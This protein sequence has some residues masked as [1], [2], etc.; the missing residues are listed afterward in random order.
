MNINKIAK[1][2]NIKKKKKKGGETREY[3]AKSSKKL[4]T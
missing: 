2:E 4:E 1:Y 3:C